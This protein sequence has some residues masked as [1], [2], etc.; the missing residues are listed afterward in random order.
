MTFRLG[1]KHGVKVGRTIV[2][3]VETVSTKALRL[4]V[5]QMCPIWGTPECLEVHG[6]KGKPY[7]LGLKSLIIW[8]YNLVKV[9]EMLVSVG[10]GREPNLKFESS[11]QQWG[12]A[13]FYV[14]LY[15]MHLHRLEPVP[16]MKVCPQTPQAYLILFIIITT[17][18]RITDTDV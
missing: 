7:N 2:Q 14:Q 11:I 1:H 13:H 16:Q 15:F 17:A 3:L 6:H 10:H 5:A 8:G 12:H 9:R 4:A 18:D